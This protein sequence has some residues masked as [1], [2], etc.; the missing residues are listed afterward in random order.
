MAFV[1][2]LMIAFCGVV[3]GQTPQQVKTLVNNLLSNYDKRVRPVT[4]QSMPVILD[5]SFNLISIIGVDEVN[6]KLETSGFLTIQWDDA[7]LTWNP[8]SNDGI[9]K[10]FLP[11]VH[12]SCSVLE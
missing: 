12:W 5:V 9:S 7:L 4:D 11:Q 2:Y 1:L 8:A 6:E 10:I 3:S